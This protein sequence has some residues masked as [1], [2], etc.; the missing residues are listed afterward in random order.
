M[1]RIFQG[2]C[3]VVCLVGLFIAS[4]CSAERGTTPKQSDDAQVRVITTSADWPYYTTIAEATSKADV[5]V[6]AVLDDSEPIM[7]TAD[8]QPFDVPE[9]DS[10]EALTDA[11]LQ[12]EANGA[13]PCTV[14]TMQVTSVL[15]GNIAVGDEIEVVQNGGLFGN[16]KWEEASTTLLDDADADEFV[17]MLSQYPNSPYYSMINAAIGALAIEGDQIESLSET[18]EQEFKDWKIHKLDK[19][20]AEVR[21]QIDPSNR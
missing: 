3:A 5:V 2:V 19:F 15:K 9:T 17:L 18:A 20:A 1:K 10:L 16:I 7:L 12:A 13:M 6:T 4:A 21:N 11:V 14:A 8:G